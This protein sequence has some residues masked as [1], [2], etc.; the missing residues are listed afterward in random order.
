METG[1][2]RCDE[3]INEFKDGKLELRAGCNADQTLESNMGGELSRIREIA[4]EILKN[5]LPRHNAPL[6]MAISGSKG[7]NINLCQMIACVG[8]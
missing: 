7:S 2:K 6:I 5:N 8:Q 3:M 4:G 1:Y